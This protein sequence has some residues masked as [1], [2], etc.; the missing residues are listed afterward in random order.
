L[1]S[2]SPASTSVFTYFAILVLVLFTIAF[3]FGRVTK[4]TRLEHKVR[5][6]RLRDFELEQMRLCLLVVTLKPCFFIMASTCVCL[7]IDLFCGFQNKFY[8]GRFIPIS[9]LFNISAEKNKWLIF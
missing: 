6:I 9:N 3:C 1:V 4:R 8:C 7:W 2:S 5:W